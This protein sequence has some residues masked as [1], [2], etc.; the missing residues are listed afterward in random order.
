[1]SP[2]SIASEG[3]ENLALVFQ[4]ILTAIGRLR[5]NRQ[6]VPDAEKF[7]A[8][9]R[10]AISAADQESRARGYS[11]EDFRIALFAVVALLDETVL[12]LRSPVFSSWPRQPMQEELFDSHT[13][14]E[15]FF[16][17]VDR[18]LQT[19]DSQNL[20]DVLEVYELSILLGYAGRYS[21]TGKGELR[22][23]RQSISDKIRRIRG[24]IGPLSQAGKPMTG[25]VAGAGRDV[26]TRRLIWVACITLV[27]GL[28]LFI[29]FRISLEGAA[30]QLETVAVSR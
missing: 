3:R 21:A 14:G 10:E 2:T 23:Y 13:A 4:E 12:N 1:M 7:R 29:G 26:W 11:P 24:K 27:L 25:E 18:L 17:N 20:A 5:A 8:S 9:I 16:K 30:K 28:T 15:I 22:S 19:S 6:A